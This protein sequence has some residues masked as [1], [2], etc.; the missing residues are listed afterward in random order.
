MV[1][2]LS[3]FFAFCALSCLQDKLLALGL[4]L[5]LT[6]EALRKS[7]QVGFLI[8]EECLYSGT[9]QACLL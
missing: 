8:Q 5:S 2:S 4:D 7:S 1:K 6:H 9:S 3:F